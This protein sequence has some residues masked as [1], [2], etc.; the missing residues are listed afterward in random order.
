MLALGVA[1][2]HKF[3]VQDDLADAGA[4]AQVQKYQVAVVATAVDPAHQNH[5]LAG[6]SGA[7]RAAKLRPF[8]I[9]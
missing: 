6:V 3:F 1:F 2:R 8:Q 7:Q 9:A 5:L 4:V